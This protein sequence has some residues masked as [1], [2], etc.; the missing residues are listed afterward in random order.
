MVEEQDLQNWNK[1]I[2]ET[3]SILG[4]RY[5]RYVKYFSLI[6]D[7]LTSGKEG[8][9]HKMD[10]LFFQE[11]GVV[12]Y[13]VIRH[14]VGKRN[15]NIEVMHFVNR[16]VPSK[17]LRAEEINFRYFPLSKKVIKTYKRIP[18]SFQIDTSIDDTMIVFNHVNKQD[19]SFSFFL[20][21]YDTEQE[22]I[23][24][25][26]FL[27]LFTRLLSHALSLLIKNEELS[28]LNELLQDDLR[29]K[30]KDTEE[31]NQMK[32]EFLARVAHELRVPLT[33]IVG[34][35]NMIVNNPAMKRET[36]AEYSEIIVSQC[37]KL[38]RMINELL[39]VSQLEAGSLQLEKKPYNLNQCVLSVQCEVR[40][41]LEEKQIKLEVNLC[42]KPVYCYVDPRSMDS[43]VL[44][45][46][47]NAIKYS[48]KGKK[49]II[50]TALRKRQGVVSVKDFGVGISEE[51]L[52]YVFDRF[53]Q[54]RNDTIKRYNES[55]VGLG[56]NLVATLVKENNGEVSV[57]SKPGRG[58]RFTVK[59]PLA[60]GKKVNAESL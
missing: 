19:L 46:V 53:R 21:P 4:D 58:S 56:L 3:V 32:S 2:S 12:S 52:P 36:I 7:L 54:F 11:L 9:F 23:E 40:F 49:I 10:R 1:E 39:E 30:V 18:A 60:E 59:F 34:F 50:A 17:R 26:R 35:A 15:K 16:L 27:T 14:E 31:A 43:I 5:V 47:E 20:Y 24:T 13:A 8:L 48:E 45:L 28:H 57:R 25:E 37:Q 41:L 29:K 33:P 6:T 51:D 42:D 38:L 22:D 55:G 44:N